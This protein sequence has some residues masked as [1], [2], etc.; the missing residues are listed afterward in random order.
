MPT[1]T[2]TIRLARRITKEQRTKFREAMTRR[3]PRTL[4]EIRARRRDKEK[5]VKI[6]LAQ[7]PLMKKYKKQTEKT[8][9]YKEIITVL[10]LIINAS[11]RVMAGEDEAATRYN[12]YVTTAEREIKALPPAL[13]KHFLGLLK[14]VSDDSH[15]YQGQS[16]IGSHSCTQDNRDYYDPSFKPQKIKERLD[17]ALKQ[18]GWSASGK[19]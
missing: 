19:W 2:K 15:R 7:E 9:P 1:A 6:F 18:K 5:L 17:A 11:R 10:E 16:Y 13:H 3:Q 8:P 14:L 4:E 12:G